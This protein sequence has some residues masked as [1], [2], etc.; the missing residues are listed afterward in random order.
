MTYYV[1]IV[2]QEEGEDPLSTNSY[3]KSLKISGYKIDFDKDTTD[4]EILVSN[5]KKLKITA[6]AEDDSSE[7]E[8]TGNEN[9]ENGSRVVVT[10]TAE[11]GSYRQYIIT[12]SYLKG[13]T[14]LI[15][16]A[17][18]TFTILLLTIIGIMFV[19]NNKNKK[20]KK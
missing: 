14:K 20:K 6:T 16:F 17:C 15:Y 3:L 19:K 10:V 5:L 2:R 7:I 1:T 13:Y 8:I 18:A 12:V 11:D 9:I 4:Y